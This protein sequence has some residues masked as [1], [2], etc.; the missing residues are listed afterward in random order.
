MQ[1]CGS[2]FIFCGFGSSSFSDCGFGSSCFKIADP[3]LAQICKQKPYEEFSIVVKNI[4]DCSKVRNSEIKQIYFQK[5]N[6][7]AVI[8]NL[9]ISLHFYVFI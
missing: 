9:T 8:T 1:G 5:F 7:L 4:K 3:D 2:A 6:K